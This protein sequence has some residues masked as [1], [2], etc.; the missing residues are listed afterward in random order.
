MKRECEK[1]WV[2]KVLTSPSGLPFNGIFPIV[3]QLG[4]SNSKSEKNQRIKEHQ[5]KN[6][7]C[8]LYD[9]IKSRQNANREYMF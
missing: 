9:A 3:R 2:G 7:I 5:K 6:K 8:K 4:F 1:H